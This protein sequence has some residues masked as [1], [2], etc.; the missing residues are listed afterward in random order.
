MIVPEKGVDPETDELAQLLL[1]YHEKLLTRNE[2]F[3][4]LMS[5]S[6]IPLR[7]SFLALLTARKVTIFSNELLSLME[8]VINRKF[9]DNDLKICKM[10]P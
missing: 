7:F 9:L 8:E 4:N 1:K 3:N 10:K 5:Q 2:K 6:V